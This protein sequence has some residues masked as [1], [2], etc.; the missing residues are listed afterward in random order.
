V[1]V[2]LPRYSNVATDHR[3]KAR[4]DNPIRCPCRIRSPPAA[5][6]EARWMGALGTAR[7]AIHKLSRLVCRLLE[8]ECSIGR[9]LIR[10]GGESNNE[11]TCSRVRSDLRTVTARAVQLAI[12]VERADHLTK[13]GPRNEAHKTRL[14]RGTAKLPASRCTGCGQSTC[15]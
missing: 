6:R 9:Q 7:L 14:R 12:V 15:V 2:W 5:G 8:Q 11:G 4:D 10:R 1:R 13:G 3:G